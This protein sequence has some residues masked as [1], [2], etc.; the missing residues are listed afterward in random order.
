[1]V[2]LCGFPFIFSL[3]LYHCDTVVFLYFCFENQSA[4]P[5][6]FIQAMATPNP[7][8]D[9]AFIRAVMQETRKSAVD[10][11]LHYILWGTL[12]CCSSLIA[13][14]L[15]RFDLNFHAGIYW[16]CTISIGYLGS[17]LINRHQKNYKTARTL[18]VRIVQGVWIACGVTM[19]LIGF[20]G[21]IFR[22]AN[23]T[24]A[25]CMVTG[26]GFYVSGILY[27]S[28]WIQYYCSAGWWL[29]GVLMFILPLFYT[30]PLLMILMIAFQIIPGIVLN[31]QWKKELD[32]GQRA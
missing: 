20:A 32:R 24:G 6:L 31:R 7:L 12:I 30:L 21:G 18:A 14:I 25:I 28:R 3:P 4:L 10:N 22:Q 9:L 2:F 5:N 26:I 15:Y 11:G 1:M 27:N 13:F 16:G 8:E 17:F 23:L 19:C 29:G